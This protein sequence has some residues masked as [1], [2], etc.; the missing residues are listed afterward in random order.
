MAARYSKIY[1][2]AKKLIESTQSKTR[3]PRTKLRKDLDKILAERGEDALFLYS[4]SFHDVN[5][6]YLTKFLAPDPFILLK[7]V[8]EEPV[9]VI[10]QMEYPRAKKQSIVKD[11]RSY[12]DYNFLQVAKSV[13]DPKLGVLKFI[14]SVAKKELGVGTK[15]CVPPKFPTIVA[16]A[17]RK[18][19]LT[20]QPMFDVIEKA[21]E[22]KDADEIKEIKK[23]QAVAEKVTRKAI[24]QMANAEVNTDGTLT[25]KE[26]GER[27]PLTVGKMKAFF[28]HHFIDSGCVMEE[29]IVACGPKGAAPHYF[30]NPE[31]VLKAKQPIILDIYP[32]SLRKR[33]CSDM[34]RTIVKGRASEKVRKM[35]EAVLEAKNASADAIKA[36]VPGSSVH[37]LCCDILEKHGYETTRGGKQITRG[38]THSLGHGVGLQVHEGPGMN[39]LYKFPL[40]EGNVLTV[41]PGLYD[42][43]IGGLR[44]EDMV[45]VTKTGCNNLTKMEIFLEI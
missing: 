33:Y 25:I 1:L 15:I 5:M 14:A 40:E 45:E 18:E 26:N 2:F 11:V 28:G 31:D 6:Y 34:T 37:N 42:P 16:D 32:Q 44:I 20:I 36:G 13:P 38:L 30:G 19:G 39:E 4:E 43:D 3:R 24:E 9:I 29:L 23:V 12:A 17:L 41:E 8:D 7:K 21:R 10:N 27:K 35:F 22:T